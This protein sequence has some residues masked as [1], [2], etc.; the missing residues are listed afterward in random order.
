MLLTRDTAPSLDTALFIAGNWNQNVTAYNA[1]TGATV[2]AV[3][4]GGSIESHPAYYDGVVY[5]S[6]EAPSSTLWALDVK[7]GE[8]VWKYVCVCVR[9][10]VCVCVCVC[11]CVRVYVC[12]C[13]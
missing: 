9:A 4:L 2:W 8:T 5:M 1:E 11:A 3:D 6:T 10:R 13:M 7:T 12:V